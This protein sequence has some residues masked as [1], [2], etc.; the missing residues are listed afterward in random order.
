MI[1]EE[2]T[3]SVKRGVGGNGELHTIRMPAN[4]FWGTL[5]PTPPPAATGPPGIVWDT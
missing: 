3:G 5:A 2:Q 4:L 1:R